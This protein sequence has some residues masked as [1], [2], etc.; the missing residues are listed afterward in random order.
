MAANTPEADAAHWIK[1]RNLT[2]LVLVIW[3]VFSFVVHL[4]ADFLNGYTF[5][6]FP[7]GY[8]LAVQGSLAVFVL[9]IF[10]QNWRQDT[11]DDEYGQGDG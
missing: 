4:F 7:L 9:L 6:G 1:T 10:F 11:I 8:Y 2:V 3:A 5:I